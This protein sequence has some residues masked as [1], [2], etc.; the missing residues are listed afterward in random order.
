MTSLQPASLYKR[1]VEKE[2]EILPSSRLSGDS[3]IESPSLGPSYVVTALT[4]NSFKRGNKSNKKIQS[5][6]L[7][8]IHTNT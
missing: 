3:G 8:E 5:K 7:P 4:K 6:N 2:K 1:N